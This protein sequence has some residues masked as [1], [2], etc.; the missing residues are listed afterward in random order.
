M[1]YGSEKIEY[2]QNGDSSAIC[3]NNF[4]AVFWSDGVSFVVMNSLIFGYIMNKKLVPE[5]EI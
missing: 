2:T 4:L 3:F 1:R 5:D